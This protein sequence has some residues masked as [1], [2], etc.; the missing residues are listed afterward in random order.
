VLKI[1]KKRNDEEKMKSMDVEKNIKNNTHEE[2]IC[3]ICVICER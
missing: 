3:V 1:K 2:I